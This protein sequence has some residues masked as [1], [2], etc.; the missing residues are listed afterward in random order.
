M[1]L[2]RIAALALAL[3][4]SLASAGAAVAADTKIDINTASVAELT[5][6]PGVG[7]ALAKRIVEYREKQ[8]PFTAPEQLMN[9]RGIGEKSFEKLRDRLSVGSAPAKAAQR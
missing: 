8:G 5:A 4:L 9:V 6:L 2:H 7:D 3:A 1:T